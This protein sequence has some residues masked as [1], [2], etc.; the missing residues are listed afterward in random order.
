ME[1]HVTILLEELSKSIE[2]RDRTI[3]TLC[4]CLNDL[5]NEKAN[6]DKVE[7]TTALAATS[8]EHFARNIVLKSFMRKN[9]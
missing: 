5:L 1:D 7:G 2:L 8:L 9:M 3:L 6:N 4:D